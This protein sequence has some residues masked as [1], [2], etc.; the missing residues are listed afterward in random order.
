VDVQ[1]AHVS[2]VIPLFDEEQNVEPLCSALRE[3]LAD[4]DHD[5]EVV[6]VD[7]GSCDGTRAR[8]LAEARRDPRLRVLGLSVNAGQTLA[9][10]TG[11]SHA[12]GQIIVSLDGDQQNDPRDIPLL[13]ARLQDGY[14]VVCGWRKHRRDAWLTRTLPS[15]I[16]N[17]LIA[18]L[19]GIPIHDNGCSL[20]AFRA[21]VIQTLRLYSE[22]HRFLPALGSMTGARIAEVVVRHHPRTHGV[23]KYGLS[24]TFKVLS[25]VVAIKLIT[26]FAS[27]PGKWF[28][29]LSLV[30]LTLSLV[31]A[32]AWLAQLQAASGQPSVVFLSLAIIFCSLFGSMM[33][34]S[35]LSELVLAN[36][37]RSYLR[38]LAE[39]LTVVSDHVP[40]GS[41]PGGAETPP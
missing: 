24:R 28:G 25:D 12:R 4:W 2:I 8:L 1:R 34:L 19:T 9:M 18:W 36:A 31:S 41:L 6:L 11:F 32:V 38:R 40:N 23:S 14:D 5:Y 17:R 27:N 13:V 15:T 7:D 29:F 35:I 10:A 37:D 3:A 21:E 26:E 22:M 16:A 20:K 30:A 39:V 33:A